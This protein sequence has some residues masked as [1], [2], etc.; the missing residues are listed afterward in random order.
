MPNADSL[1]IA[2]N[3]V[4]QRDTVFP[5]QGLVQGNGGSGSHARNNN[6]TGRIR[7]GTHIQEGMFAIG[8]LPAYREEHLRPG[9]GYR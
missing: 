3:K 1:T 9:A 6:F 4:C 2:E 5:Y 7:R 8:A